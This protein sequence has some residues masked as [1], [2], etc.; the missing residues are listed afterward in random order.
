MEAPYRTMRRLLLLLFPLF[1]TST[2]AFDVKGIEPGKTLGTKM[3]DLVGGKAFCSQ[4]QTMPDYQSCAVGDFDEGRLAFLSIAGTRGSVFYKVD[5]KGILQFFVFFF[6]PDGFDSVRSA[7]TSKWGAAPHRD[8][9]TV[10][11]RMGAT[12]D[13]ETY[14]WDD[15]TSSALLEK[16]SDRVDRSS[17]M[18][19]TKKYKKDIDEL[20]KEKKKDF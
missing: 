12:F 6:S 2:Y 19:A 1:A 13:Q 15:E 8:S 17:L 9:G 3:E 10:S 20:Y 5:S 16:R 14:G 11:N 7:A 4:S 18:I